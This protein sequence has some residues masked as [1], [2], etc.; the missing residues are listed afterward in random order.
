MDH[1]AESKLG[2]SDIYPVSK[3]LDCYVSMADILRPKKKAKR[4]D[5]STI[6]IGYLHSR[7]GSLENKT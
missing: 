2:S 1:S 4:T 6:T 3:N 7:Q 5:L